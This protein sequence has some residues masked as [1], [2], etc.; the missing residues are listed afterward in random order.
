MKILILIFIH[1]SFF[2]KLF[3]QLDF[4]NESYDYSISDTFFHTQVFTF[5]NLQPDTFLVW[6]SENCVNGMNDAEKAKSYFLKVKGDFSLYNLVT[7]E[8]I[9]YNDSTILFKTFL[10]I[11]KPKDTFKIII[12]ANSK[13]EKNS[14]KF[15]I[16][17]VKCHFVAVKSNQFK[18]IE[19]TI[20]YNFPFYRNNTLVLDW[21]LISKTN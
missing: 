6:V 11:L 7:E 9:K 14:E 5:S 1:L 12:I 15:I 20:S 8:I 19:K 13:Q 17:Y 4:K 2:N 18:F 21:G 16:D 10:K 3:C